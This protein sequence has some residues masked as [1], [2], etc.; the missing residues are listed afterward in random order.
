MKNED[1]LLLEQV[2]PTI[3]APEMDG[4]FNYAIEETIQRAH[5]KAK[6]IRA[7]IKPKGKMAEYQ[8]R[9][10]ELQIS[11]AEKNEYDEPMKITEELGG[12][13]VLEKYVIADIDDPKSE[14]NV[15][16]DEL[17]KEYDKVIKAYEKKLGFLE[18]ENKDFEPFWITPDQIP[19][20]I[21]RPQMKALHLMIKLKS[22]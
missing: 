16:A 4:W 8:E 5:V 19:T 17:K 20:G 18:E 22:E 1:I 21:S 3:D 15:K 2:L 9:L 12:G 14:F 7:V 10:K 11:H 6:S 13:R